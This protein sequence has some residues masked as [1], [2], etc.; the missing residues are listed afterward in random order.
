MIDSANI[1]ASA[2]LFCAGACVGSFLNLTIHRLP[3][4]LRRYWLRDA[5]RLL[6]EAGPAPGAEAA[7]EQPDSAI[8]GASEELSETPTRFN[9]ATP[10][11][12]CRHCQR[13]LCA[14]ENIP[15]ISW[16]AL[17]GRCAGCKAPIGWRSLLVELLAGAIP[18]IAAASFG[19]TWLALAV[20]VCGWML[21]ALAA[22]DQE[23]GLLPD[24]L[25]LPLL[26]LGLLVNA[27]GGPSPLVEAV[28]GAAFAWVF[29]WGVYWI[30]RLVTGR[31][32]MGY[33]D[34]KLF[35]AIG[36]WLG[37]PALPATLLLAAL[38]GLLYAL[39]ALALGQRDRRAP[40]PFGPFLAAAG[41]LLLVGQHWFAAG[42]WPIV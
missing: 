16:L 23:T 37:W 30:F 32:G 12:H 29:L 33:G 35:A 9:L 17:R 40:I 36:A 38:A 22:I 2:W 34:F 5:K 13:P 4:M 26:W 20:A 10:R 14:I 41:W 6:T 25:T 19:F 15:I 24:E 3:I 28:L 39:P 18:L 1:L 42:V 27:L 31:E 21:L 11:S 8:P 7:N